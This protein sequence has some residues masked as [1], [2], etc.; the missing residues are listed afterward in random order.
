MLPAGQ[1][2]LTSMQMLNISQQPAN[3]QLF[4]KKWPQPRRSSKRLDI[5]L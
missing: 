2:L 1:Q 3:V 5:L 4:N